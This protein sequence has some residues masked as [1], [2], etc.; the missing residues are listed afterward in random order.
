MKQEARSMRSEKINKQRSRLFCFMLHVSCFLLLS[1]CGGC[2]SR[3]DDPV[4]VNSSMLTL[5]KQAGTPAQPQEQKQNVR[6]INI[7]PSKEVA[8]GASSGGNENLPTGVAIDNSLTDRLRDKLKEAFADRG[9]DPPDIE[10]FT[11]NM[12]L[13]SFSK[14]YEERGNKI[15]RTSVPASQVVAPLLNERPDLADK[16]NMSNY[17]GITINQVI[18]EGANI[19][20]ADKYIDP[21]TYEVVYK[22]FVTVTKTK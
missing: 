20:A 13:D 7:G 2:P 12:S 19:S 22:T 21:E 10:I 17:A 15:Q 5:G 14:Y 3:E 4:R 9:G 18:V 8:G 16:I 11:G 6:I 1:S